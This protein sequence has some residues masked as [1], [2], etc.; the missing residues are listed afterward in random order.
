V[1]EGCKAPRWPLLT[2]PRGS[3][4]WPGPEALVPTRAAGPWG[5]RGG[6]RRL[7]VP[8]TAAVPRASPGR[9]AE[10][11]A[12]MTAPGLEPAIRRR[13]R[14]RRHLHLLLLLLLLLLFLFLFLFLFPPVPR[15][16]APPSRDRRC[17][18]VSWPGASRD[19][20]A[21][22]RAARGCGC[23]RGMEQWRVKGPGPPGGRRRKR[24][25]WA[26]AAA[27]AASAALRPPLAAG[28]A[29]PGLEVSAR[30]GAVVPRRP[31]CRRAAQGLWQA[32]A[33]LRGLPAVGAA[34]PPAVG[35]F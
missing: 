20:L 35:F 18:G 12:G 8:V 17:G 5:P 23:R 2:R 19:P 34:L 6:R 32:S 3:R 9:R 33:P 30:P 4:C 21:G 16:G 25:A 14:R 28:R 15:P 7:A 26:W 10:R 29:G 13:R 11:S 24:K 31:T 1:A 27:R 22:V